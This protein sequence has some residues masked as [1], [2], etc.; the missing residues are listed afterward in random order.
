M[1]NVRENILNIFTEDVATSVAAVL[2]VEDQVYTVQCVHII[3]VQV[4]DT[5][6][7]VQGRM[8]K[9]DYCNTLSGL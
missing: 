2:L 9:P 6:Y 3:L 4:H 8:D 1:K 5:T 7:V